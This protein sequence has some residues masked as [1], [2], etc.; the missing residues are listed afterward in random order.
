MS[1]PTSILPL[2]AV[3][4][5]ADDASELSLSPLASLWRVE[6]DGDPAREPLWAGDV[7]ATKLF[8]S[9]MVMGHFERM[10]MDPTTAD[11][12]IGKL[13]H[14]GATQETINQM[15][16]LFVIVALQDRARIANQPAPYGQF[17]LSWAHACIRQGYSAAALTR[18]PDAATNLDDAMALTMLLKKDEKA[19]P[20]GRSVVDHLFLSGGSI[21]A[22]GA[23]HFA[24]RFGPHT[25]TKSLRLGR[26]LRMA[27]QQK[28]NIEKLAAVAAAIS[29]PAEIERWQKH[30]PQ[31]CLAVQAARARETLRAAHAADAPAMEI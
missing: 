4:G 11:E 31:F 16:A 23:N 22:M 12:Q 17:A 6:F 27:S 28:E 30:F 20:L 19:L 25:L 24:T 2:L 18:Y 29:E 21:E 7:E 1:E 3:F 9:V 15:L 5:A 10:L 14:A 13:S 8:G 26:A